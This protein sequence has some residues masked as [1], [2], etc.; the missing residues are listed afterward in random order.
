M[1]HLSYDLRIP[2][3]RVG[4]YATRHVSVVGGAFLSVFGQYFW[5]DSTYMT[6]CWE[7][8]SPHY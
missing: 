4:T 5:N 3:E 2:T 8:Y 7:R 1:E 6:A